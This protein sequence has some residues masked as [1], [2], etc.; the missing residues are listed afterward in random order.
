MPT[1]RRSASVSAA[2]ERL[3][4]L[5]ADPS[6]RPQWWPNVVRV[7]DAGPEAW[8]DVL[9]AEGGKPVRADLTVVHAQPPARLRWRQ[10]LADSPFE[11]VLARS[12]TEIEIVAL[13]ASTRVTLTAMRRLRGLA[14]FGGALVRRATARQLDGALDG[15]ARLA[16]DD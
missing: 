7:E 15:L 5:I 3:W 6:R 14:L 16:E 8:T 1:V 4:E 2:P 9:Q 12:E 10:E 13:E 11:R